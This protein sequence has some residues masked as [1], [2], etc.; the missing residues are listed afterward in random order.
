[1]AKKKASKKL[2]KKKSA[3]KKPAKKKSA[4]STREIDASSITDFPIPASMT[5]LVH[6]TFSNRIGIWYQPGLQTCTLIFVTTFFRMSI[7]GWIFYLE[8]T[9]KR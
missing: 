4:S 5:V 8:R 9:A 3:K 2:A 7:L 6:G 1:M